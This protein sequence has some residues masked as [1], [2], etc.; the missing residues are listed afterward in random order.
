MAKAAA[1]TTE[2]QDTRE[3]GGDRPLL[4]PLDVAIKK[5]IAEGKERGY[6]TY[7]TL[8]AT[9]PPAQVSS[10]QIEDAMSMLS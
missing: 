3:E 7:D 1:Q 5:V 2:T 4:D 9:L 10:E 8:N 6:I